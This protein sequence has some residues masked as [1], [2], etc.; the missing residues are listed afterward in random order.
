MTHS[1]VRARRDPTC[2]AQHAECTHTHTHARTGDCSG[3]ARGKAHDAGTWDRRGS[4]LHMR[5]CVNVWTVLVYQRTIAA[6]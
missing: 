6:R 5:M 4:L 1:P 2:E 3:V